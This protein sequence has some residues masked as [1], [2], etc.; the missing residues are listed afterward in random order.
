MLGRLPRRR[1]RCRNVRSHAGSA[2]RRHHV[3]PGTGQALPPTWARPVFTTAPAVLRPR[4]LPNSAK[5]SG[6]GTPLKPREGF[7]PLARPSATQPT[8]RRTQTA[9]GRRPGCCRSSPC[10]PTCNVRGSSLPCVP[11]RVPITCCAPYLPTSRR[12]THAATTQFGSA[13]V[14]FWASL[15]TEIPKSL[16]PDASR[17]CRSASA[18]SDSNV[19]SASLLPHTGLR[20]P[21]LCPSCGCVASKLLRVAKPDQHP[22]P[23]AYALPLQLVPTS[24]M[25][26]GRV[27]PS[28]AIHDGLRPAQCDLNLA[29]GARAGSRRWWGLLSVALQNTLPATLLGTPPVHASMPGARAPHLQDVLHDACP[30]VSSCLPAR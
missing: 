30:P 11:P 24:P 6:P 13:C 21:T 16:P 10:C 20:G 27:G 28:G 26:D 3:Y 2:R 8:L 14:T 5:L 29:S 12:R 15:M 25:Q 4:A 23:S 1:L 18:D 22:L 19:R 7:S 9:S 17:F